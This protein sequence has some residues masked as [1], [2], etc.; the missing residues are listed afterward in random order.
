MMNY[1]LTIEMT[2]TK[3]KTNVKSQI[4]EMLTE[5]FKEKFGDDNVAIVRTGT[6]KSATN[7]LGI[8]VG[9]ADKNGEVNDIVVTINPVVKEFEA[10]TTAKKVYTPF[11]FEDAIN[12]YN[13]YLDEQA[14]KE[15][16]RKAKKN[17]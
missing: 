5:F 12:K 4:I 11:N 15:A 14:A 16:E 6:E 2:N 8:I 13:D 10:K 7:E 3:I 17:S 9:T 1:K